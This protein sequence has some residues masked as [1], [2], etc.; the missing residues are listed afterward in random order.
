MGWARSLIQI[1]ASRY[2]NSKREVS[3]DEFTFG[4][5]KTAKGMGR[6]P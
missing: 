1:A 6:E 5:L 4:N 2:A 3:I